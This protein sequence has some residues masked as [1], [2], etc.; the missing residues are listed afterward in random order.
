[1]S[2][3]KHGAS[4]IPI[5]FW[6][7]VSTVVAIGL[8]SLFAFWL[9]RWNHHI[10]SLRS[11]VA[12][13]YVPRDVQNLRRTDLA[14]ELI[15]LMMALPP[16]EATSESGQMQEL[17]TARRTVVQAARRASLSPHDESL[18]RY[19]DQQ[20]TALCRRLDTI[21]D[22]MLAQAGSRAPHE[23]LPNRLNELRTEVEEATARFGAAEPNYA[24]SL[25]SFRS[26][27]QRFPGNI[28]VRLHDRL[29]AR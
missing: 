5:E 1:M 29:D 23:Q 8:T 26:V 10:L 7:A 22:T 20:T 13:A 17:R 14:R 9:L 4:V 19:T 3:I 21:I 12:S 2:R 28:L 11:E 18:V 27:C 25:E 16:I 6:I 24:R 15:D